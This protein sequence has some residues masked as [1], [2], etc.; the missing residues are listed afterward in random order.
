MNM[1]MSDT[2]TSSIHLLHMFISCMFLQSYDPKNRKRAFEARSE[3]Y[4]LQIIRNVQKLLSGSDPAER[5]VHR[6]AKA[7]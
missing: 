7:S 2:R 5:E 6:I 1:L 4:Q 3:N